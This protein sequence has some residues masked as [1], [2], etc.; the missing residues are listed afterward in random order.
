MADLPQSWKLTLPCTRAEAEAI[1]NDLMLFMEMPSPPVLMTS[2]ADPAQPEAWQLDAYFEDEPDD[3]TIAALQRLIPSSTG[4]APTVQAL[5]AEDWL[6]LSQAGLEPISTACFFVHTSAYADDLPADRTPLRIDAG[7]AFGTGQ[8]HTTTGCILMLERLKRKG[9]RFDEIADI[10]TGTG[11]LAFVA[12]KLWPNAR[13]VASDIDPIAI[14][15]AGENAAINGIPLGTGRGKVE[16]VTAAGLANRRIR[17]NAPYDLVIANILA[18]PLV[19]LAPAMA[20]ALLPGG[21]LILA[22]LL[23]HQADRV[24]QAYRRRRLRLADRLSRDEWPTL[25][26]VMR[27]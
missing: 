20:S 6:T 2:E 8:H 24:A 1:S 16:L 27:P 7:Q 3:G 17:R 14:A 23:D 21:S 25:R 4:F 10:G 9:A 18:D 13:V 19:T 5:A 12:H 22:G 11:L 15:V 26:M